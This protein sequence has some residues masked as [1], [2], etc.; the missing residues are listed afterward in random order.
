[1]NTEDHAILVGIAS[2]PALGEG[3]TP[4][5]L[6]GPE[7]DVDAVFAWMTDPK[8]GGV[9]AANIQVIRT[10]GFPA[11]ASPANALPTITELNKAVEN[12]D[13]TAQ[14]NRQAEKGLKVGRRLYIYMSGH[15]FSP[16]RQRG[17]LYAANARERAGYNVHASGWLALLQDAGYFREYVLWMDCCMNRTSFLPPLDPPIPPVNASEPPG[18]TFIAY[19]AQ[20]PFK[21]VEVEIAEDAHKYHG[22]F[23]WALLQGLKG[24][25]A[26]ANGRVTGRSLADWI[27]NAQ[28]FRLS[29]RDREDADVA[30]EP[31]VVAEDPLLIFG[32]GLPPP[33][34]PVRLSFPNEASGKKARL[35]SGR[36]PRVEQELK[37]GQRTQKLELTPGL[38]VI[39]VPTAGLRQG[40]EVVAPTAILIEEHGDPIV[41][42]DTDQMLEL[43]VDPGDAAAEIFVIDRSFSLVDGMP[44]RLATPL[45]FGIYKI[46]TRLGRGVRERVIMLDR[47]RPPLA[48][49]EIVQPLATAAPVKGTA[50]THEYQVAAA[51]K[52]LEECHKS[53]TTDKNPKLMVMA[54][55]WSGKD[56]AMREAEPWKGVTVINAR[57][58]VVLDL[59]Q[60]KI[61]DATTGDPFALETISVKPG[62]YFLHLQLDG[63]TVA[64]QSLVVVEGWGL[65]VQILRRP[66]RDGGKLDPRPRISVRMRDLMQPAFSDEEDRHIEAARIAL[67]DERRILSKDLEIVLLEKSRD[68][69]AGIIGAHLLLLEHERNPVRDLSILNTVVRNLRALV[70]DDHPDVEALSLRCT[71][72]TLRRQKP[73]TAP[74]MFQRSWKLLVEASRERPALV[75][76]RLYSR[77]IAQ[78]STAPFFMWAINEDIKATSRMELARAVW[79]VAPEASGAE[80]SPVASMDLATDF[81]RE[82][83]AQ[84]T[85]PAKRRS[86][87]SARADAK[88]ARERAI[89]S[90]VPSA[91]LD[92][93]KKEYQPKAM[94]V[95]RP[96]SNRDDPAPSKSRTVAMG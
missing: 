60:S 93:L 32:R 77:V 42:P 22:V 80:S 69:I 79:G 37:V 89:R 75:P 3:D 81:G 65:E 48:P 88:R 90:Q 25:A 74:P 17:C 31:E 58:K 33:A 76:S 38:Y 50:A 16:G 92:L 40:F 47:D 28:A 73:I 41:V 51:K 54:R 62:I 96:T 94:P 67:A 6:K 95:E 8:G 72:E 84:A 43:H 26:D 86:V 70:G 91:A 87:K 23:T 24:A 21:A 52:A 27:R 4:L 36:P 20:R 12:L 44:G 18:A 53:W 1:M 30:K 49:E 29:L 39:D 68:P 7:N 14:A 55:V 59:E 34:Y 2:Y 63:A 71:D 64:E 10:S 83:V 19:A 13:L 5:D 66:S 78:V 9:P 85:E 35:W 15:G 46:K 57:G 82:G 11:P 45:P 56:G 61:R